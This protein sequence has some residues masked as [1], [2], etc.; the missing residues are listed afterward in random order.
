MTIRKRDQVDNRG[1]CELA[2]LSQDNHVAQPIESLIHVHDDMSMDSWYHLKIWS[3][4]HILVTVCWHGQ[5]DR[6]SSPAI[7]SRV[8]ERPCLKQ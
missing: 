4:R 6:W 1:T 2:V 8:N 3:W 7:Y 5:E